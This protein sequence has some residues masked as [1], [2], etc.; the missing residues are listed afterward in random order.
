MKGKRVVGVVL[1]GALAIA[2][3]VV[4]R[5]RSPEKPF[6][7]EDKQFGRASELYLKNCS[8][9][10]GAEGFGD[11]RSAHLL[12]PRPR[13]FS[14][15]KMLLVS[16]DNRVPTDEDLFGTISRGMPGSA[17]PPW[18]HLAEQDRRDL[19]GYVRALT[20]R[21]KVKRLMVDGKKQ[22][23]AEETATYLLEIGKPL[24][25]PP[26][27][28]SSDTALQRG[29]AVYKDYCANCHGTEGRGDGAEKMEDDLGFRSDPRDFTKGIFKGGVDPQD[30]AR[31]VLGGMPG[32]AMPTAEFKDPGDVWPIV[33]YVRSLVRPGAQERVVQQRRAIQAQRVS[34]ELAGDPAAPLWESIEATYVALMP[35][36]WRNERVEGLR[37]RAAHDGANL[38]I[39]LAWDDPTENSGQSQVTSFGDAVALQF[40]SAADP[41]FFGMGDAAAFANIWMWKAAWERDLTTSA[42]FSPPYPRAMMDIDPTRKQFR[43]ATTA[44]E[45]AGVEERDPKFYGGWGAG[46]PMSNPKR[47][48][49]VENLTAKGPGTLHSLPPAAQTVQGKGA[50]GDG[51][52]RVV[53]LRRLSVSAPGSV[54]FQPGQSVR[55]A[56]G[57]WEGSQG[58]RD[59]QKSVTIW[60][61]LALEP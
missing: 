19:V 32:S 43:P 33:H 15:G 55:I 8:A 9:C 60:H 51:A 14:Q 58:D 52:W 6:V 5:P 37:V 56:F 46:N 53:L 61:D 18:A 30:L 1:A 59:G 35:L 31:R 47:P 22:T 11:G 54:A 3:V 23:Q 57:V 36:W 4:L 29:R 49:P 20:H 45:P 2:L 28:S 26:E 24:E 13:D 39:Q 21:G 10:H 38:A 16:T 44:T 40:S 12:W 48:S 27:T 17:M 50:R 41:P 7:L 42:G 34:P 25:L